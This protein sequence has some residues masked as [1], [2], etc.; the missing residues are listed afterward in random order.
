VTATDGLEY[1][2]VPVLDGIEEGDSVRD[3]LILGA[4]D[5][6]FLGVANGFVKEVIVGCSD[7]LVGCTEFL[8][9]GLVEVNVEP[10]CTVLGVCDG[11]QDNVVESLIE[12]AKVRPIGEP[13]G[14]VLEGA[15]DSFVEDRLVGELVVMT[16]GTIDGKAFG[17]PDGAV[18]GVCDET[19][20]NVMEGLIEGVKV[21]FLVE[22]TFDSFVEG[23]LVG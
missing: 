8:I 10:S 9:E 21:V 19:L 16:V 1:V 20:N 2:V 5:G 14:E 7:N 23:G 13:S 15:F 22:G 12:G 6:A 17:I 4:M 18:L 11:T 3:G